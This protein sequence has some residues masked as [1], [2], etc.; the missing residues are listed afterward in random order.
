MSFLSIATPETAEFSEKKSKFIAYA[1][2][3]QSEQEVKPIIEKL[4]QEH[5][6]ARHICY[7]FRLGAKKDIWKAND[8]GEPSNSA[9]QPILGQIKSYDLTNIIVLVVRYFGGVKLGVG[10][11]MNAYKEAA[12]LALSQAE[13]IED[14]EK[15]SLIFEVPLSSVDHARYLLKR[16]GVKDYTEEFGLQCIFKVLVSKENFSN[17]VKALD[18]LP[19]KHIATHEKN[20]PTFP[21]S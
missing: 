11:L 9:G 13:N 8:D 10:G 15:E 21:L 1:L 2:P 17:F 7:A 5:P 4:H 19:E 3:I 12:H 16:E 14:F 18:A 6:Q 20:N